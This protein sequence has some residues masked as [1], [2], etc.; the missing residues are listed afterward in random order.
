[1][2]DISVDVHGLDPKRLENRG[3][4]PPPELMRSGLLAL[5]NG[6]KVDRAVA[7]MLFSELGALIPDQPLGIVA[8]CRCRRYFTQTHEL[9]VG[10]R[11][12][13]NGPFAWHLS[14]FAVVPTPLPMVGHRGFRVVDA[15]LARLVRGAWLKA[16]GEGRLAT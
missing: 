8:V 16:R 6:K 4:R 12:W 9:P 11:P 10:Q 1:M 14:D 13:F 5:H 3:Y 7:A 2:T 15:N